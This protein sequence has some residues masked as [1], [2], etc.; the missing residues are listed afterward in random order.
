M[1]DRHFSEPELAELYDHFSFWQSSPQDDFYLELVMDARCALDVGC[2]TGKLQRVARE[3]G[4]TGRLVGL[5]PAGAM[6]EIGRR[7]RDDIEW[8]Q[9][10]LVSGPSRGEGT[11]FIG[12]F[13]LITMSGHAFQ[14]FTTDEELHAALA[15]VHRAL[16]PDGRFVFETRNPGAR[17]W[18]AW[19]PER[20]RTV[21]GPGGRRATC[22]H[23][24][25]EVKGDLITF[26]SDYSVEGWDSPRTS[27]STLRFLDADTLNGFLEEAGLRVSAQYGYWDRS[28]LTDTSEEIITFARPLSTGNG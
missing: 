28:P 5:D 11:P 23:R 12:E 17:A 9:G 25:R 8:I 21:D 4:H 18:E 14:V 19:N 6:L 22:V 26:T 13:D 1:V 3:C 20:V 2:G 15:A 10:D 16:T 7:E 24:L 27:R